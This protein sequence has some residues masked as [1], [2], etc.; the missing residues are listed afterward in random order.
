MM[1]GGRFHEDPVA[2]SRQFQRD[3]DVG[4]GKDNP[5]WGGGILQRGLTLE[6]EEGLS[7]GH[8]QV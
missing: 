7:R 8:G 4:I 6:A 1:G 3:R 5:L 2:L